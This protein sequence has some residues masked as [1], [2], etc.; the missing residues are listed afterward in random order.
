MNQPAPVFP[1]A[2]PQYLVDLCDL[3]KA[4]Y[5]EMW[6]WFESDRFAAIQRESVELDLLKSTDVIEESTQTDLYQ[7]ARHAA[8][9]LNLDVPISLYQ[10]RQTGT[11]NASISM[12]PDHARI[13]LEGDP[14][15]L[16]DLDE[17]TALLGHELGHLLLWEER[18]FLIATQMLYTLGQAEEANAVHVTT[19][20]RF[21][22]F[23][24]VFCDRCSVVACSSPE[25]A[26]LSLVKLDAGASTQVDLD[27]CLEQARDAIEGARDRRDGSA[28]P[29][30]PEVY[31]RAR[32]VDLWRHQ[33]EDYE[34]AIER[35]VCGLLSLS[36]QDLRDQS[37]IRKLTRQ[38]IDVTLQPEWMRSPAALAH[39]RLFFEDYET[40]SPKPASVKQ[41]LASSS[42]DVCDYAMFVLL[43]FVT[44]DRQ[45]LEPALAHTMAIADEL[46]LNGDYQE[47][48][49]KELR[50]RKKQLEQIEGEANEL[51][52]RASR[53]AHI[54]T[55]SRDEDSAT[56]Q[57]DN[58]DE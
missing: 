21:R 29:T 24:E 14:A 37:T 58:A 27:A 12:D 47:L 7:A 55:P 33:A 36:E 41:K 34:T 51:I 13:V 20:Q 54:R 42:Q 10:S 8:G 16:L 45:R 2:P 19:L 39:A 50:M 49:R 17:L 43:D 32:A 48:T 46:G 22:E 40:Q 3:L 44:A 30:H 26:I 23:A 1:L 5:R 56:P 4:E 52:A 11:L 57:E 9:S 18:D 25:T 31:T 28:T 38:L 53:S 35:M 15:G 6:R